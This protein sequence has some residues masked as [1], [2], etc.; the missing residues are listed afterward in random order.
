ML[1]FTALA[2]EGG[3]FFL[4]PG[5]DPLA[6]NEPEAEADVSADGRP[7]FSGEIG[8]PPDGGA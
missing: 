6:G 3:A 1:A 4:L 7:R 2:G 8:P 5:P